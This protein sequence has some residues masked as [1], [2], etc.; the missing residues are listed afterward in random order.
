LRAGAGERAV[1]L[2]LLPYGEVCFFFPPV[3]P[4]RYSTGGGMHS[5]CV[6]H[7][8]THSVLCTVPCDLHCENR[9]LPG[10]LA[11]HNRTVA[12]RSYPHSLCGIRTDR[13]RCQGQG[14]ALC[15]LHRRYHCQELQETPSGAGAVCQ[16]AVFCAHSVGTVGYRLRCSAS[17]S[18]VHTPMNPCSNP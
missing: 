4:Y 1:C 2:L 12:Y 10:W 14:T 9:I 17:C 11:R 7:V 13:T 15:E 3:L 5:V 6:V 18:Y 8:L 16:Q